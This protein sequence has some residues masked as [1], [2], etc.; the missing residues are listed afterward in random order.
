MRYSKITQEAG[1]AYISQLELKGN[2]R[3]AA[4][5]PIAMLDRL[6]ELENELMTRSTPG[7]AVSTES[8]VAESPNQSLDEL[9][10]LKQPD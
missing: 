2:R 1:K 9:T 8:M 10:G 3:M 6:L 7:T 4:L 5:I